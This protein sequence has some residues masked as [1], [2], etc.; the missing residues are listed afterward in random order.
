M[1]FD[2]IK[3]LF[4]KPKE[5]KEESVLS[6]K[7]MA[8]ARGEPYVSVIDTHFDP[9]NPSNG[10]FELDWNTQF[11][12]QLVAAGYTGTTEEEIVDKWFSTIC[13][14]VVNESNMNREVRVT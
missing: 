2:F 5:E 6:E 1:M 9:N 7:E 10:Y 14:N 3:N 12:Q 4:S 11:I 13:Q 8:T